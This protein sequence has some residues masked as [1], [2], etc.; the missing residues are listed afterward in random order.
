L[1]IK[2][3]LLCLVGKPETKK[4]N[5]VINDKCSHSEDGRA[6]GVRAKEGGM[7]GKVGICGNSTHLCPQN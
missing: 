3:A 2:L 7:E 5:Q 4:K 6:F 1:E